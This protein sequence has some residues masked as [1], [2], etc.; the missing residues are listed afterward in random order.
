MKG[1]KD[2]KKFQERNDF[3]RTLFKN[4]CEERAKEGYIDPPLSAPKAQQLFKARFGV[5]MN[6]QRMYDLRREI[7][8]ANG[9]DSKGRPIKSN[10]ND[11]KKTAEVHELQPNTS[12][13]GTTTS[14][15]S[16]PSDPLENVAV[17]TV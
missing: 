6:S 16:D 8:I 4:N 15:N 5:F 2:P 12:T 3:V 10:K 13:E 17:V 7:F 14:V 11:A 9:L 1:V